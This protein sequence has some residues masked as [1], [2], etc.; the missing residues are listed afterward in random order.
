MKIGVILAFFWLVSMFFV[1]AALDVPCTKDRDCTFS[2]GRE[3]YSC[4]QRSCEKTAL[5]ETSLSL[6]PG[7][8]HLAWNFFS[9]ELSEEV[10]CD[11]VQ[12]CL[13]F[14]PQQEYWYTPYIHFL[15]YVDV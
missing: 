2:L 15:L 14:A 8:Q 11:T 12:G 7:K 13:Q 5:S 3:S 4:I 6:A 10:V 1:E 9:V